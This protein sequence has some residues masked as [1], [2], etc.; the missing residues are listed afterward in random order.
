M[1]EEKSIMLQI[2]ETETGM[3]IHINE[4]AYGNFG[5]VG[6]MEHIKM[7]LLTKEDTQLEKR[8]KAPGVSEQ[9]Y[10]A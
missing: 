3:E 8:M 10:D 6:L 5:L 1:E 2:V 7:A 9:K 4:K